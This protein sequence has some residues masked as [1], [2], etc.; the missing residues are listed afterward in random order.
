MDT[1]LIILLTF[2]E[3]EAF[4]GFGLTGFLTLDHTRVTH[5]QALGFQ[6]RTIL[7]V[8]LAECA[9]NSH[10]QSFGLS[11]DTTTIKVGFD[12]P[13]AFC[14][15]NLESL[16]DDEL[17]R[18]SGEIF[19]IISVVDGDFTATGFHINAGNSGLSSTYSVDYLLHCYY[20]ISLML[21]TLGF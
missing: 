2:A 6:C 7:G 14:I 11:G 4:A 10:S 19:F 21:M 15:D 1:K 18:T 20:L 17:Q 12:I 8:V 13:F 16:V 5:Q 3:L 9:C